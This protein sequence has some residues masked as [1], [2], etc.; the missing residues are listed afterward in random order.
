MYVAI[1]FLKNALKTVT[2]IV[3][4]R[5]KKGINGTEISIH[6]LLDGFWKKNNANLPQRPRKDAI[7]CFHSPLKKLG[8]KKKSNVQLQTSLLKQEALI[9]SKDS[10]QDISKDPHMDKIASQSIHIWGIRKMQL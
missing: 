6:R 7:I 8:Q 3:N 9:R 2:L 10:L 4:G 1:T 5:S